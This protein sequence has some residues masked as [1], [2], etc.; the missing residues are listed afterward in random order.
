MATG[1]HKILIMELWGMGDVVMMSA[2][3]KPLKTAFPMAQITVLCQEPG[4]QILKQ[5]KEISSF[6]TFKFPWTVLRGKYRLW[7]WDW[8]GIFSTIAVL[9]HAKFDLILDGR[10]DV[11]DDFLAFLIGSALTVSAPHSIIAPHKWLSHRVDLWAGVLKRIGVTIDQFRPSITVST[12]EQ[13]VARAFIR[14]HFPVRP[15]KLIGI[16]PGAAQPVRRWPLSR[17]KELAVR[18]MKSD[19][20]G[21]IL[22]SDQEGLGFELGKGLDLPVFT[23]NIR[24]LTALLAQVDMLIC[25]DT[26]VM[27]IATALGVPVVAV[28][29]PGDP[30]IIGPRGSADIL[31][32]EC[33]YRPC[34][35]K[36]AKKTA[37]CL[38]RIDVEEV[39]SVVSKRM[40]G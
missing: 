14:D 39:W 13:S 21:T 2:I 26:G 6:V 19:N 40:A 8:K 9:R 22:F 16:H 31:I 30:N 10:G 18:L 1:I 37:D 23:G 28:F 17:F 33:P 7:S 20:V 27:H 34:F 24:E 12:E 11:R 5:N 38:L 25:N 29:G 36:C 4:Q 32:K 3:L 15:R 35:D